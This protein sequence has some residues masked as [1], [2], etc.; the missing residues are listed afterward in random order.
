MSALED[1]GYIEKD[2]IN[3]LLEKKPE[4]V[5][6]SEWMIVRGDPIK[7]P[8]VNCSNDIFDKSYVELDTEKYFIDNLNYYFDPYK[9]I[10]VFIKTN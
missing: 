2:Y 5:I 8:I 6:C 9:K 1:I 7:N 10:K 3:F 4:V